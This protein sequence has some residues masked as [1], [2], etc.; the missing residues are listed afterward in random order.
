MAVKLI[1]LC[2]FYVL[3]FARIPLVVRWN[4]FDSWNSIICPRYRLFC[5]EWTSKFIKFR[6]AT[7]TINL[8]FFNFILR[9]ASAQRQIY[10]FQ[11]N[12]SSSRPFLMNQPDCFVESCL[13]STISS[14]SVFPLFI[15]IQTKNVFRMTSN[16]AYWEDTLPR[17]MKKL[18]IIMQHFPFTP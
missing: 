7:I 2:K 15:F 10:I 12:I 6:D 14:G 16:N 18:F 13:C 9:S 4:I 5:G 8:W 17:C 3:L 1:N 11:I